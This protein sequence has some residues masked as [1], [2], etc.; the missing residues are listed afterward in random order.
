MFA[1]TYAM[2]T[3]ET[4]TTLINTTTEVQKN[5]LQVESVVFLNSSAPA[6]AIK[7]QPEELF[8]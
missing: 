2:L 6:A 5:F 3:L 4:I 7:F 8:G 1:S